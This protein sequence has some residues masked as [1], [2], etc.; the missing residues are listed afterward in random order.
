L[1]DVFDDNDETQW[2]EGSTPRVKKKRAEQVPQH[3]GPPTTAT[4][5]DSNDEED[6]DIIDGVV[7]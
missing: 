5:V 2:A 6:N 1:I 3:R 7:E 4:G